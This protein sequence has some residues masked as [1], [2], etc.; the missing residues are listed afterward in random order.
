MLRTLWKVCCGGW[1]VVKTNFS[2]KLES[3][4]EQYFI[5]DGE[6]AVNAGDISNT[7]GTVLKGTNL[8]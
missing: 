5:P 3:Q 8:V 4:A 7:R 2:V 6:G 1:V